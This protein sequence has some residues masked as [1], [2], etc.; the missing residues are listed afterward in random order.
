MSKQPPKK[1][2]SG[3]SMT[4]AQFVKMAQGTLKKK[5]PYNGGSIYDSTIGSSSK[6]SKSKNP[7]KKRKF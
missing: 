3:K 2:S 1:K 7:Y 6:S 4:D 5:N